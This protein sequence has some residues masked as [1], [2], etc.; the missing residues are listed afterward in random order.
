VREDGDCRGGIIGVCVGIMFDSVEVVSERE[1]GVGVCE[2]LWVKR[3]A[4]RLNMFEEEDR[5]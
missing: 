2:E 3:G 4:S 5:V 1:D